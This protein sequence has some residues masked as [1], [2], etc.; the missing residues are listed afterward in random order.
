[1][2]LDNPADNGIYTYMLQTHIHIYLW[3]Q[4]TSLDF[5]PHLVFIVT[6]LSRRL[7][8]PEL[9]RQEIGTHDF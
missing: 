8:C 1:M 9:V 3:L 5:P 6:Y 4:Y 2:D 7:I